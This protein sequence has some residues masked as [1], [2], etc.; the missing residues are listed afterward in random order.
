MAPGVLITSSF[1][2][3]SLIRGLWLWTVLGNSLN[4]AI[5]NCT[6]YFNKKIKSSK[7]NEKDLLLY[8]N[9]LLVIG[10]SNALF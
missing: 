3:C 7:A 6:L 2:I 9:N 5:M 4:D 8:T 1:L 10:L